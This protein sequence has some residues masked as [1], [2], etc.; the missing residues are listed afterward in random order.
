M[1]P[2]P[3][4]GIVASILGFVSGHAWGAA[5]PPAPVVPRLD[6]WA[7]LRGTGGPEPGPASDALLPNPSEEAVAFAAAESEAAARLNATSRSFATALLCGGEGAAQSPAWLDNVRANRMVVQVPTACDSPAARL[8]RSLRPLE[9]RLSGFLPEDALVTWDMGAPPAA[10]VG[11]AADCLR[12]WAPEQHA[13][14][15]D[16]LVEVH[17]AGVDPVADLLPALG[18]HVAGGLLPP[19]PGDATWPLPRPVWLAPVVDRDAAERALGELLRW[20]AGAV[21]VLTGGLASA[22]VV[23]EQTAGVSVVGLRI[24]SLVRTPLPSPSMAVV[25]GILVV[26]PVRSAVWE[27][28]ESMWARSKEGPGETV[29]SEDRVVARFRADLERLAGYLE[30]PPPRVD[31]ALA[32]FGVPK[33]GSL[34]ELLQLRRERLRGMVASFEAMTG[35]ARSRPG[36][37]EVSVTLDWELVGRA[38]LGVGQ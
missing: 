38:E 10:V 29:R 8:L 28:V 37:G 30:P 27:T 25:D 19:V 4:I 23:R 34:M 22:E 12:M 3:V 21:A 11:L 18:S 1:K 9:E 35:T 15:A 2:W 36:P 14:L 17:E 5:A 33:A 31:R 26:A 7:I 32:L 16:R 20:E 24:E 6:A 13:W